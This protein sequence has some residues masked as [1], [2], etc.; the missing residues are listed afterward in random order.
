MLQEYGEEETAR[1]LVD[2]DIP[3][4]G[5]IELD[6]E[7]FLCGLGHDFLRYSSEAII[8]HP[9]SRIPAL[10][11]ANDPARRA[12]ARAKLLVHFDDYRAEWDDE[13]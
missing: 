3:H 13:Q 6:T 12:H 8:L 11:V 2:P 10:P 1:R 9:E 5:L 4:P 7:G